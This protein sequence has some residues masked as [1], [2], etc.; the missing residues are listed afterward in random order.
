MSTA[1]EEH[2]QKRLAEERKLCQAIDA[3]L[4]TDAGRVLW[5]ELFT[6]AGYN[7]SSIVVNPMTGE[8]KTEAT[9]YNESRRKFYI[10][11]RERASPS[12]LLPVEEMAERATRPAYPEE[13][14]PKEEGK[15]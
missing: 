6:R 14:T 12:L 2:R 5:A 15:K 9:V 3:V 11:L 4:K 8:V 13:A 10:E 7:K 1:A